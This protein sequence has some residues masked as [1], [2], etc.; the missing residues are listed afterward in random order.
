MAHEQALSHQARSVSSGAVHHSRAHVGVSHH[1]T[2]GVTPEHGTVE[3][4][5][6]S[7]AGRVIEVNHNEFNRRFK[8]DMRIRLH[9]I[10]DA[11]HDPAGRYRFT[12]ELNDKSVLQILRDGDDSVLAENQR[13]NLLNH[14]ITAIETLGRAGRPRIGESAS[15]YLYRTARGMLLQKVVPRNFSADLR[16]DALPPIY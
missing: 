2:S 5:H 8:E 1:T 10:Y 9:N 12:Q 13:R 14:Q 4:D 7:D 15:M 11:P 3:T 16:G 6:V